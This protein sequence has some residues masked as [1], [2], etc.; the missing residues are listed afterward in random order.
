MLAATLGVYLCL[1]SP[2]TDREVVHP[3]HDVVVFGDD[4]LDGNL[5]RGDGGYIVARKR[6]KL[7]S[8]IHPRP[9][10]R[11]ELLLSVNVL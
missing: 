7:N 6:Q 4:T 3:R 1:V 8:L 11:R 2:Q 9:H 5:A 10:F